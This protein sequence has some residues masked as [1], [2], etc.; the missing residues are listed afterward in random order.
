MDIVIAEKLFLS[1][2]GDVA[3]KILS[4]V[5]SAKAAKI[6]ERLAES[7]GRPGTPR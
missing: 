2:R 3:G 4:F 6:S 7:Y 5:E 1:M